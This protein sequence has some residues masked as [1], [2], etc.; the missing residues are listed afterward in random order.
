MKTPPQIKTDD[1]EIQ[2]LD[3]DEFQA[4]RNSANELLKEVF[5]EDSQ[6]DAD[7]QLQNLWP[8]LG[9]FRPEPH[10][11]LLPLDRVG[12]EPGFS[13][14]KVLIAYFRDVKERGTRKIHPS[15]PWVVKVRKPDQKTGK[16]GLEDEQKRVLRVRKFATYEHAAFAWPLH[17]DRANRHSNCSVL[18]S[19]FYSST[20]PRKLPERDRL[21]LTQQG[22]YGVLAGDMVN[23]RNGETGAS[24]SSVAPHL[25]ASQTIRRVFDCLQPLHWHAKQK[26]SVSSGP[27]H[28]VRQYIEYLRGFKAEG[29]WSDAWREIWGPE[30]KNI[31]NRGNGKLCNPVYVLNKLESF[32]HNVCVGAIHGDLHPRNIVFTRDGSP[33]IIDFGWTRGDAH[34]AKDFVLMECNLRF[35]VLRPDIPSKALE[36]MVNWIPFHNTFSH[37]GSQYVDDRADL[38]R[39]L[40]EI[41]RTHFPSNTNWNREYVIPLFLTSLGLLKPR[42]LSSCHNRL[43]AKLTIQSL[44]DYLGELIRSNTL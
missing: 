15:Q 23:G 43:A 32:A 6:K 41:A 12:S 27:L 31:I 26:P 22:L 14:T 7:L 8:G 24:I 38:I 36:A 1:I 13:G 28:L 33:R 44:A 25:D 30:T 19:P 17:F 16:C 9:M 39:I 29:G 3:D 20:Q 42:T 10:M 37:T 18:W 4:V 35:M 34:I 21:F 5:E 2:M 11:V 40:H